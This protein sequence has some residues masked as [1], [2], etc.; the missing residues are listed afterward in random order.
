MLITIEYHLSAGREIVVYLGYL[1][2]KSCASS[3]KVFS[4]L[5]AAT[6][7]FALKAGLWFR[8]GRLVMVISS[9]AAIMP[10]WRGKSTYPGCSVFPNHL[11]G[12]KNATHGQ[13]AMFP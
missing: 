2:S 11:Y 6:A 7:T 1:G 9:L 13:T 4:P 12:G 8:R 3:I 10:P 5:I